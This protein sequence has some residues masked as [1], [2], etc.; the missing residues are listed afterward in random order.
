MSGPSKHQLSTI[1]SRKRKVKINAK[2]YVL[3]QKTQQIIIAN[4][5][6]FTEIKHF[7][8]S[9]ATPQYICDND[10]TNLKL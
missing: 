2:Y 7:F 1:D 6:I 9:I 3:V 4:T 8:F 5:T 10:L